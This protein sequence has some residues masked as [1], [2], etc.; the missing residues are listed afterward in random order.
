V[1]AALQTA[2][3]VEH[4]LRLVPGGLTDQETARVERLVSDRYG[5]AAFLTAVSS[6]A[7]P[8]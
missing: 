5:S 2:F 1:A 3:E 7:L 6:A 4:G 8:Q